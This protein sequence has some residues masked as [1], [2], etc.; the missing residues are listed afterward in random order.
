MPD[1]RIIALTG[2]G[3]EA[4]KHDAEMSGINVSYTEPVNFDA[5][6]GLLEK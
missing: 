3:F 2:L 6:K 1:V 4:P 5:L